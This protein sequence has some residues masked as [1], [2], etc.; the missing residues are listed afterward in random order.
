MPLEQLW[1]TLPQDVQQPLL[2][3]L[4]LMLAQRIALTEK[5]QADE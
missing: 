5:E 1:E 4:S 3:Q 2:K